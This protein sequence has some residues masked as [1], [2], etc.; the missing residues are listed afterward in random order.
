MAKKE[1]ID[2]G[3]AWD[4]QLSYSQAVKAGGFIF[5]SGQVALDKEGN[6]VGPGDI[7][8]QARKAYENLKAVL[9]RGGASLD[10]VVK[11]TWF[12]RDI[13]SIEPVSE[14][15]AQYFKQGFPAITGVQVAGLYG[16]LLI[17]IEAVAIAS[18]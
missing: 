2:P 16:G 3:W 5:V 6:V 14:I 17:E 13:G 8:A 12:L 18:S 11:L 15:T 10:D 9:Q 7:K 1:I 4:D